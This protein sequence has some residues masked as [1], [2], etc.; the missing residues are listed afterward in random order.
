MFLRVLSAVVLTVVSFPLVAADYQDASLS[1]EERV[2]DLLPR[3]TLE[4]KV[5]QMAQ[6]VGIEH[7][8]KVRKKHEY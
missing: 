6:Y 3:M 7:V 4:E 5:G 8:A 1:P 2:R